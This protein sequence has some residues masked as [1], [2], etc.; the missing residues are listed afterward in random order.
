MNALPPLLWSDDALRPLVGCKAPQVRQGVCQRGAAK[1]QGER[2]PGPIGPE[3]L[4]TQMVK[5]HV[6]AL[7]AVF[8]GAIRALAQAGVFEA[9]V[10]GMVDATDLETTRCSAGGGQ[11]TRRGKGEDKRGQ[12]H[13]IEVTA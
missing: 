11:V 7:E 1:R 13:A 4:A 5:G 9:K 2:T 3:T 12:A 8:T 10:T 6:R